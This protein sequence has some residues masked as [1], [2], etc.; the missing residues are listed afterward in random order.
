MSGPTKIWT[1]SWALNPVLHYAFASYVKNSTI[2]TKT[3][4]VVARPNS[5]L[6]DL[7]GE[8]NVFPEEIEAL[9]T[10]YSTW[11]VLQAVMYTLTRENN[12]LACISCYSARQTETPASTSRPAR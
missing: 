2:A 9:R 1:L 7:R 5:R 12:E 4:Q 6:S 3:R 11:A 10:E 8:G